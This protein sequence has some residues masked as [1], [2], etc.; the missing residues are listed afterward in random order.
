M[1]DGRGDQGDP[2]PADDA[3]RQAGRLGRFD[4]ASALVGRVRK[5]RHPA[6]NTKSRRPLRADTR[7]SNPW[8]TPSW[9]WLPGLNPLV[10]PI[11]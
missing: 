1:P 11:R 4:D 2:D 7:R 9:Y 6:V 3:D 10:A 5:G 8:S